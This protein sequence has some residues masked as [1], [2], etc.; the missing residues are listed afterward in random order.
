MMMTERLFVHGFFVYVSSICLTNET[1]RNTNWK[2]DKEHTRTNNNYDFNDS[3]KSST[4]TKMFMERLEGGRG[5][6]KVTMA[7]AFV[8]ISHQ[9]LRIM[10]TGQHAHLFAK[11]CFSSS[12][13]LFISIVFISSILR[14][15]IFLSAGVCFINRQITSKQYKI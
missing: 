5:E 14:E 10:H 3:S 6:P 12:F 4:R 9:F 8:C 15:W 7:F 13:D 2:R 1:K 11:N